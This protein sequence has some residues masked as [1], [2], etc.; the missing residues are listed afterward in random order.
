MLQG[1]GVG[2][3][4][5]AGGGV[6]IA[7][8]VA[9]VYR[10][11]TTEG[12]YS[13]AIEGITSLDV[14]GESKSGG[15]LEEVKGRTRRRQHIWRLSA[16]SWKD[17]DIDTPYAQRSRWGRHNDRSRDELMGSDGR[18]VPVACTAEDPKV[19]WGG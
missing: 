15:V 18:E 17:R 16:G 19:G 3:A 12:E 7:L 13:G 14:N 10:L 4:R 2:A 11:P 5:G 9:I 6:G 1:K 8:V